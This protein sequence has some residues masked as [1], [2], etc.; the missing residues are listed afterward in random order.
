MLHRAD[1]NARIRRNL[2]VGQDHRWSSW[3]R[4]RE[5]RQ[6]IGYSY[7]DVATGKLIESLLADVVK[8]M[9]AFD[10][11]G[12]H[13]AMLHK[14][15]NLG[16]P[17]I[18]SMAISAVDNALWDLKA[19]LLDCSLLDLLG[20]ARE[21]AEIYG[22]GGFTSYSIEQLQRSIGR[23]GAGGHQKRQNEDWARS[24]R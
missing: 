2:E 15:R 10:V 9:N 7:A 20:A 24:R 3:R 21:S 1:G 8:G 14:I 13:A 19:R 18:A 22:S 4:R 11:P 23:V 12:A 6:G 5:A 16:R 17:G